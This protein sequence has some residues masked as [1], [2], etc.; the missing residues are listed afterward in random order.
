MLSCGIVAVF[1]TI[2]RLW[3]R[4]GRFWWDDGYVPL[5]FFSPRHKANANDRWAFFSLLSL[6][7]Q[8]AAVFLRGV[9]EPNH[10][11]RTTKVASYYL[12]A[13]TFYAVIW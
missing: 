4:R 6:F 13:S 12:M 1:M 2:W 7:A 5:S 3:M 11:S 10:L 9:P 8:F